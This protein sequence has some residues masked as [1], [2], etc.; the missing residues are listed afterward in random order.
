MEKRL[1]KLTEATGDLARVVA[2]M[3][4]KQAET[5]SPLERKQY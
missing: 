4:V 5:K 3:K 2:E 1:E